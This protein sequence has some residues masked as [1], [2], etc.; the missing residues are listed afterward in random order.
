M[1]SI[2]CMRGREHCGFPCGRMPLLLLASLAAGLVLTVGCGA[3][4]A[5][6]SP[7]LSVDARCRPEAMRPSEETLITCEIRI[8]NSG[9][10]AVSD[11]DLRFDFA[12]DLTSPLEAS[13]LAFDLT[14][15]GQPLP[16]DYVPLSES[17][18]ELAPGESRVLVG[19]VIFSSSREGDYGAKVEIWHGGHAVDSTIIRWDVRVGAEAPPTNLT[20][21]DSL[22]TESE[23]PLSPSA[24]ASTPAH[25]TAEYELIVTNEGDE[26][27]NEVTVLDKYSLDVSLSF[28]DPP[29]TAIDEETRI[30]RWEVGSLAPGEEAR[31]RPI[32]APVH[33]CAFPSNVMVVTAGTGEAMESY[34]ARS[35]QSMVIG[36]GEC[37]LH[38]PGTGTGA[39]HESDTPLE[40]ALALLFVGGLA[41][42]RAIGI[43]RAR[44][45]P[46]DPEPPSEDAP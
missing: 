7:A 32:F 27:V 43:H 46:R 9:D 45:T 8:E 2:R 5:H 23:T 40:T 29:V 31:F 21:S 36:D 35:S 13:L 1:A 42:A 33:G 14:A 34:V 37:S 25:E 12:P 26:P 44:E 28:A 24:Q 38:L 16:F 41:V 22:L 39:T 4:P 10:E 15:D 19:R 20:I 6:A 11:A 3:T 18:G 17:I 30:A